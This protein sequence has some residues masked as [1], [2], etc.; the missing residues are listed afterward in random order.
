MVMLVYA[1]KPQLVKLENRVQT[2][3]TTPMF[4][5]NTQLKLHTMIGDKTH[6]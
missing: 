5:S 4:H 2:P 6:D 1:V 3:D